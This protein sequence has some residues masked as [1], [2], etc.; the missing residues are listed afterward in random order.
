MLV[1]SQSASNALPE[2]D[3]VDESNFLVSNPQSCVIAQNDLWVEINPRLT[4]L[5]ASKDHVNWTLSLK[6]FDCSFSL[7][8][9]SLALLAL[10][11]L[12][13]RQKK[14]VGYNSCKCSLWLNF[15]DF[16]HLELLFASSLLFFSTIVDCDYKYYDFLGKIIISALIDWSIAIASP[17]SE[18]LA[19]NQKNK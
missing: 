17:Q 7:F 6:K 3:L 19:E 15:S 8:T 11:R 4:S 12:Q 5:F 14:F 16:L 9:F 2:V 10:V 18:N 1:W 13:W